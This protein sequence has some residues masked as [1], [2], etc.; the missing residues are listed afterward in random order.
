MTTISNDSL[1]RPYAAVDVSVYD[2]L[3]TD[4]WTIESLAR[5]LALLTIGKIPPDLAKFGA[6]APKIPEDEAS[7]K[8]AAEWD[9]YAPS[10]VYKNA[11]VQLHKRLYH[12]PT[13]ETPKRL[14][15]RNPFVPNK[16]RKSVIDG[17]LIEETLM[18]LHAL[19][20]DTVKKAEADEKQLDDGW[21][22]LIDTAL[23]RFK[24]APPTSPIR[25]SKAAPF[26]LLHR[27]RQHFL[28]SELRAG[29]L[30]LVKA[31]APGELLEVVLT[32]MKSST[33]EKTMESE[34]EVTTNQSSEETDRQELSDRVATSISRSATV[35]ASANGSYNA[36]LWNAGGSEPV[37]QWPGACVD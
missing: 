30:E 18:A 11:L 31:L 1:E 3:A 17:G 4:T 7:K 20:S 2:P 19:S 34:L 21:R 12:D 36:V 14:G 28:Y 9:A 37:N 5:V 25:I 6:S 29:P 22:T 24:E 27:F 23:A 32:E 26:G 10:R 33:F 35:T 16:D 13:D 8:E 15:K